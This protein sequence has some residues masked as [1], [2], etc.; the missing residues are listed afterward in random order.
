MADAVGQARS[1]FSH[2]LELLAPSLRWDGS[3]G[4]Q[5]RAAAVWFVRPKGPRMLL[6]HLANSERSAVL[7]AAAWCVLGL[8]R[9]LVLID[10]P[11]HGLHPEQHAAFFDG[12]SALMSK[13]Q[14]IAA[15]TSP[16]ILR[17]TSRRQLLVLGAAGGSP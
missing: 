3:D 5:G 7:I 13:G 6:E 2:A 9:A 10:H 11:E 16:A 4:G 8:E 17:M 1:R 15:T 12:L 14:L